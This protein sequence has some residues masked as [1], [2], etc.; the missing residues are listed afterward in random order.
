M[1]AVAGQ[2]SHVHGRG[3][4]AVRAHLLA[5]IAAPSD[6]KQVAA[7]LHMSE[8]SLRRRLAADGVTLPRAAGRDQSSWSRSFLI[9]GGITVAE[10]AQRL[11]YVEVSSFSQAFRRWKSVGPREFRTRQLAGRRCPAG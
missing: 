8:R 9:T 1:P 2:P 6:A 4:G 7:T 10:V 3:G 5:R 11:G